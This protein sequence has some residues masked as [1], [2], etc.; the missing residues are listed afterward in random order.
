MSIMA[1]F[2]Q[3][4]LFF[5]TFIVRKGRHGCKYRPKSDWHYAVCTHPRA[6]KFQNIVCYCLSWSMLNFFERILI[7]QN[8]VCYCLSMSRIPGWLHNRPISKHRM[9]L[10]ILY[11]YKQ[12]FPTC[13]FKTSYVTVYRNRSSHNWWVQGISKHRMLLFIWM[14]KKIW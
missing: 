5:V 2:I 1:L 8:I 3:Y 10:F 4:S 6:T 13:H 12:D 7:F 14:Q 9:L 11:P